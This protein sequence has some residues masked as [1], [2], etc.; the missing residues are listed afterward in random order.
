MLP[1][2]YQVN[3]THML[4]YRPLPNHEGVYP[5]AEIQVSNNQH[6]VDFPAVIDT[7]A[8]FSLISGE[9]AI[10]LGLQLTNGANTQLSSLGGSIAAWIHSVNMKMLDLE[11]RMNLR[12]ADRTLPRNI[13][14][15]DVLERVQIGFREYHS[16]VLLLPQQ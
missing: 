1:K 10:A 7:G 16:T 9:Y 6:A 4:R 11:F 8:M 15:R 13:I 5:V 12:F 2:V 14:G 3:Y